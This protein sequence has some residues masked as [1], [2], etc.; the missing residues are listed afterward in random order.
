MK[1]KYYILYKYITLYLRE[2]EFKNLQI[3]NEWLQINFIKKVLYIYTK[4]SI[5]KSN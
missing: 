4:N 3:K 5:F 2:N 1:N